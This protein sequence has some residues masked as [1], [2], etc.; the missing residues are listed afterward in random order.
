MFV[1][2]EQQKLS[3]GKDIKEEKWQR[4]N[5]IKIHYICV[6]RRYSYMYWKLLSN[7]GWEGRVKG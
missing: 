3:S 6:G 4:I 7:G 2:V 1:I 5:N